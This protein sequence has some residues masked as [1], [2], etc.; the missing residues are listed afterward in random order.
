M[1][2]TKCPKCGEEYDA[3]YSSHECKKELEGKREKEEE[4]WKYK[5]TI[6]KFFIFP[7]G[8][9]LPLKILAF[10][11]ALGGVIGL[12]VIFAGIFLLF[13]AKAMGA[14]ILAIVYGLFLFSFGTI[15]FYGIGH[16]K[17]W[18]FYLYGG[19]LLFTFIF[20]FLRESFGAAILASIVPAIIF[21]ILW[22]YRKN[23]FTKKNKINL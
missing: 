12:I 16:M 7:L 21:L 8:T 17:R 4:K 2:I 15:F 13:V 11:F 23:F 20:T 5:S 3:F 14:S 19:L 10:F 1:P 6:A 18:A 22:A 9:P